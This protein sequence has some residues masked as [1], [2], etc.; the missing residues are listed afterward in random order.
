[1]KG[2]PTRLPRIESGVAAL[3]AQAGEGCF[4]RHPSPF[5]G[6]GPPRSGGGGGGHQ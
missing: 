4:G 2:S 1:M 3:P 6:E 5:S